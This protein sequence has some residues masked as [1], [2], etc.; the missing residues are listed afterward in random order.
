MNFTYYELYYYI[1]RILYKNIIYILYNL[2]SDDFANGNQKIFYS[3][4]VRLIH[5]TTNAKI[6]DG[7]NNFKVL[8]IYNIFNNFLISF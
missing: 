3:N 1:I 8:N 7:I 6:S 2:F 5:V 4:G